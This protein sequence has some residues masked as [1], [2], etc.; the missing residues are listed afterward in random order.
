MNRPL[1]LITLLAIVLTAGTSLT[2]Q[3][4]WDGGGDGTSWQDAANWSIDMVP[5]A[6]SSVEIR[7]N[8]IITGTAPAS[9]ARIIIGDSVDVTL[10]RFSRFGT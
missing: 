2:A 6:D 3:I 7:I 10:D 5:P 1:F 8:A 9:I 4:T